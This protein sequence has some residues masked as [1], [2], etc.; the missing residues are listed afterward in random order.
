MKV[1]LMW[2]INDFPAYGMISSR[3]MHEKLVCPYCKENN[4]T[5]TLTNNDKTF[6]IATDSFCR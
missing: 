5:F 4:K 3:N 1:V 6:F 2:I